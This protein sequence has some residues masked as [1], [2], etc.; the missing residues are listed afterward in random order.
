[1]KIIAFVG[2]SDSGKTSLISEL[3]AEFKRRGLRTSVLKHTSHCFTI[4]SEG[5]DTW[6]FA[7]AGAEGVAVVSPRK[8]AVIQDTPED[9]EPGLK[10][11]AQHFFPQADVVL[12]EGGKNQAG[13]RKIEVLREDRSLSPLCSP[14]E[15]AAFIT[16]GNRDAPASVPAFSPSQTGEICDFILS[17]KEDAVS[18][19]KLEVNGQEI[20]LNPFVR[21]VIENTLMG[22][23][24]SLSGIDPNPEIISLN[25]D[26][27]KAAA[28]SQ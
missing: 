21:T 14:G 15:L 9:K 26:R 1:M 3:V 7:R 19:I 4:D 12:V 5:K 8:W 2:A 20:L 27:R 11:L 13:L 16:S 25:I 18:D 6:K 10:A 24:S 28:P 17:Q 23:V 22:I